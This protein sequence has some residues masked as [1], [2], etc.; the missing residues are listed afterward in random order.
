MLELLEAVFHRRVVEQRHLARLHAGDLGLQRVALLAQLVEAL[1]RV[2]L[3]ALAD[4][5]QQRKQREQARLGAHKRPLGER[6][7]PSDGLL[8]RGRELELRLVRARL[9]KLAQPALVRGG[10]VVQVLAGRL[11]VGVGAKLLAQSVQ[12][13]FQRL[14]QVGL[15][16]HPHIGCHKHPMQKARHQRRMRRGQQAPSRVALAQQGKGGVV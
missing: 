9:V 15:V 1:D 11:G 14:G 2:G 4:L 5:L 12:L 10:P 6:E 13:I 16:H 8:G 3:G 7:Q